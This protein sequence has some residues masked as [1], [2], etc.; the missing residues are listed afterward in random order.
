MHRPGY[1]NGF[2]GITAR[3]ASTNRT[4]GH[5]SSGLTL[6]S[7]GKGSMAPPPE[8]PG[9]APGAAPPQFVGGKW[10][11]SGTQP[12]S[13]ADGF[14]QCCPITGWTKVG[15]E[16]RV[17]CGKNNGM[18]TCGP[19]PEGAAVEDAICCENI[20]EWAPRGEPGSD[21]CEQAGMAH[22]QA[23]GRAVPGMT[24]T[25]LTEDIVIDQ[26]PLLSPVLL[27][28]GGLVVAIIFGVTIFLKLKS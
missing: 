10:Q 14:Y 27:V 23:T 4:L 19:L 13:A 21:P 24:S 18:L 26:G 1:L 22:S 25:M 8:P 6:G 3:N 12:T 20:T 11:C 9:I 2:E 5:Y 17:P 15:F 28:G 16:D 7:F